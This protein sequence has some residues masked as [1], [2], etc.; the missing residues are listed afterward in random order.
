MA[1]NLNSFNFG[2][3]FFCLCLNFV[4]IVWKGFKPCQVV[5]KGCPSVHVVEHLPGGR[6][7]GEGGREKRREGGRK[8]RS[9][10]R[11]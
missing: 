1:Y 9:R 3:D 11:A 4:I 8:D 5:F 2:Q 6:R 7:S 10:R